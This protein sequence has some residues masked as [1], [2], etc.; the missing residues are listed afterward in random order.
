MRR[1]LAGLMLLSAGVP[2]VYA[3]NGLVSVKSAHD[4]KTTASRLENSLKEKGMTVF[5]RI[6]HAAAGRKVGTPLRP[7]ELFVFGNPKVGTPL[8]L[9]AQTAAIDL[10]QK[11]LI[12]EDKDGQVWLSYNDPKYLA[13]RHGI[14]DCAE[15]ITKIE[16]AL[17]KFAI[18]ATQP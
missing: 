3:D 11:A 6:D 9:C 12:W 8:M 16:D 2:L 7:T 1:L 4:V 10:P 13:E 18:A 17:S 14:M 5:I 15:I